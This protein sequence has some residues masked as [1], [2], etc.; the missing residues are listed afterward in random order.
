MQGDLGDCWLVAAVAILTM[1]K[2]SFDRVV[3]KN[4]NFGE[5]YNGKFCFRFW[6]YGEWVDVVVD[7]RLP[8]FE[9][10]LIYMHSQSKNEFWSALLEKA[11]AKLYGSYE[12]LDGGSTAEALEDFTGGLVEEVKVKEIPK[13][14]LLM[15]LVSGLEKESL[16]GCSFSDENRAEAGLFTAHAYSITGCCTIHHGIYQG[17]LLLRI[18]NPWGNNDEWKGAWCDGAD[19]WKYL[20]SEVRRKMKYII[21]G[22]GEFWMSFDDFC[23]HFEELEI[24]NMGPESSGCDMV[25]KTSF[26]MFIK[27]TAWT[28]FSRHGCWDSYEGSAGGCRQYKGMHSMEL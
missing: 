21:R 6:R 28:S 10:K 3:M 11:Y 20:S 27:S 19:E 16:F 9:G 23:D 24:C 1:H 7:D 5:N 17:T 2:E 13:E 26:G 4:Q 15:I 14:K 12:A 8:T 25:E 22:D 18:R